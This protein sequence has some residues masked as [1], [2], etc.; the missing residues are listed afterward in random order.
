MWINAQTLRNVL[1]PVRMF[2]AQIPN[3]KRNF[4]IF[5]NL[6]STVVAFFSILVSLF[7]VM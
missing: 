4:S 5:I 1:D 3:P 6:S 7:R 2:H